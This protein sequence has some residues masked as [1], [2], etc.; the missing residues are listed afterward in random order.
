[1]RTGTARTCRVAL[2]LVLL[3]VLFFPAFPGGSRALALSVEEEREAGDKFLAKMRQHFEIVEEGFAREY[4]NELGRYLTESLETEYFPFHFYII[5]DHTL[6]AF[7]GPG[8][9]IFVFSGLIELMDEIDE[10]AAVI[11]HEVGHVS[12]RHLAQRIEQNKKLGLVSMAGIL[13]GVLIGGKAAKAIIAGTAAA[14]IQAQL[15]YSRNDERQADQ[16]GFKYMD[17]SGFDPSGMITTLKKMEK[18]QWVGVDGI[19]PYLRTHPGGPERISNTQ[20]MLTG[21]T[22]KG[23]NRETAGFREM[24]PVFKTILRAKYLESH[25]AERLFR[26]DLE[27]NPDSV[28]AHF[29]LGIIWK[30]RSE[31]AKAIH[32]LKK[33]LEARPDALPILSHLGEAY[34][35]QGL[36]GEAVRILERAL[37]IDRGNRSALFLLAM[38]HKNLQEYPE[39]IRIL[40]RLASMKPVQD[41]V[42]YNL[43]VAYGRQSRLAPAHYNFGIHFKR[44]KDMKKARFHFEKALELSGNDSVLRGRIQEAMKDIPAG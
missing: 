2:L 25:E 3:L 24:F 17:L 43:G 15:S 29:G 32:H 21:Y 13:A 20:V 14:G 4:I 7:A 41:E 23:G 34:Q 44:R 5:K 35:L 40:E 22:P 36:D 28:L 9:H 16:L 31:Y 19:P 37:E 1:M 18:G 26:T 30:E 10:L 38:S 8:G 42:F 39:A 27:K 12:A 11:C 6:N 33:A